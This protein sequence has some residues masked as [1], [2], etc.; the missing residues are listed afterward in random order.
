[1]KNNLS[2]TQLEA[3]ITKTAYT[4]QSLREA[5]AARRETE[6]LD[7]A[8]SVQHLDSDAKLDACLVPVNYTKAYQLGGHRITAKDRK[9]VVQYFVRRPLSGPN[10]F[11]IDFYT[12]RT[13]L[14]AKSK[15]GNIYAVRETNNG[16]TYLDLYGRGSKPV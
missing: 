4:L 9:K 15:S 7:F 12:K 6:N 16:R 1:M 2:N 14:Y 13:A 3:L 8:K 10:E 5:L 11:H